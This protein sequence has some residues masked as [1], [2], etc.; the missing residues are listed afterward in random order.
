MGL[1]ARTSALRVRSRMQPARR[2]RQPPCSVPTPAAR[3]VPRPRG[4]KVF[5]LSPEVG[6]PAMGGPSRGRRTDSRAMAGALIAMVLGLLAVFGGTG[7]RAAGHKGT[8]LLA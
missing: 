3:L 4:I 7:A 6:S 2:R 8:V 1:A 5:A